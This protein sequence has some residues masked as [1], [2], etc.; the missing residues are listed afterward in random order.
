MPRRF[1]CPLHHEWEA[2]DAAGSTA[3]TLACPVCGA[4]H[5]TRIES[6]TPPAA[7]P[8]LTPGPVPFCAAPPAP[9]P[10][11]PGYE[12]LEEL[13]HGGMGVVYK[14]L[15]RRRGQVVALKTMRGNLDPA[16]LY[17]FKQEFHT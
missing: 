14:A 8:D 4:P 1:I 6:A 12:V 15:D 16:V 11:V 3:E 7:D 17:R 2:P 9:L 13:G 5:G 10:E